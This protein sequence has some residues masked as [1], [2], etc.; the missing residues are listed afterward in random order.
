MQKGKL[1]DTTSQFAIPGFTIAAQA[2]ISMRHPEW[3]LLLN[4]A[5]QPFWLYSS[6][7]AYKG[8]GQIGIL[9]TSII[10]TILISLGL[11]N[12]WLMK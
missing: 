1:F 2:I 10:M 8:A 6:W 12:Y 3:G 9:I 11:A 4:L 7:R 5:A